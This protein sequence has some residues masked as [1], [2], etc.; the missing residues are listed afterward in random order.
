MTFDG[1]L[2]SETVGKRSRRLEIGQTYFFPDAD[3][4]IGTV[5]CATVDE[6]QK[7]VFY[8][9]TAQDG[10]SHIISGEISDDD[11]DDYRAHKNAY[12]GVIQPASVHAQT[13]FELFEWMVDRYKETPKEKLIELAKDAP[14]ID[15]LSD[16]PQDELVLELCERWVA[17][18][19]SQKK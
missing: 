15:K 5:T 7:R 17:A 11:L 10:K 14:D 19:A 4:I 3:R 18:I 13:P 2:P 9:V 6:N 12:F 1:S 8:G 16:L